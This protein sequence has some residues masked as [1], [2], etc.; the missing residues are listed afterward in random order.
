M[1]LEGRRVSPMIEGHF[2]AAE[3]AEVESPH[4]GRAAM[5]GEHSYI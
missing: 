1:D 5:A 2:Y 4:A 3:G